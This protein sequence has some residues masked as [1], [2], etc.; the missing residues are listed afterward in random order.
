MHFKNINLMLVVLN[1]N[2]QSCRRCSKKSLEDQD[3]LFLMTIINNSY[4]YLTQLNHT[5]INIKKTSNKNIE[6]S[7]IHLL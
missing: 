2:K 4:M 5:Q 6:T 3:R 1:T 7:I